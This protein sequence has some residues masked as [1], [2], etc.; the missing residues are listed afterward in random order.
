M[1]AALRE[2]RLWVKVHAAEALVLEGQSAV[3]RAWLDREPTD[4]EG[5]FPRI[6]RWRLQVR[7]SPSQE[8]R[9]AALRRIEGV[10]LDPAGA[11]DA[12]QAVES[13]CKLQA[14]SSPAAAAGARKLA[15]NGTEKDRVF[16]NWFLALA[17]DGSARDGIVTALVSTDEIARLRAGYALR[18]LGESRPAALA[19]LAE[20]ADREPARSVARPYLIGSAYRLRANPAR[21]S[22]WRAALLEL[23]AN[24]EPGARLDVA[25]VLMDETASAELVQWRPLLNQPGDNRIAAGWVYLHVGNRSSR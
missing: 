15:Q 18:W 10:F 5:V 23:V 3:V 12:L 22:A 14:V 20:A 16:A 13:L 19:K 17:G 24:G 21:L 11:P 25:Q 6:G 2:E 9:G 4:G 1:R 7:S 8:E